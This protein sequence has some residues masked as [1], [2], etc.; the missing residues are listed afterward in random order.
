VEKDFNYKPEMTFIGGRKQFIE[1]G[2][3][4]FRNGLVYIL[5]Y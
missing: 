5:F 4:L 2:V 3:K 1:K